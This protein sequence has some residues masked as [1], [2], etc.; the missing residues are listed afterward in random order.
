MRRLLIISALTILLAGLTACP[1]EPV[2]RF[3]A[4][5]VG[6]DVIVPEA[7]ALDN[8]GQIAG[9]LYDSKDVL[10]P[11]L[12]NN[13]FTLLATDSN[14]HDTATAISPQGV[15]AGVSEPLAGSPGPALNALVFWIYTVRSA[16]NPS[17]E[18]LAIYS[19]NNQLQAAGTKSTEEDGEH[20][21]LWT[22]T[23]TFDLPTQGNLGG[24]ALDINSR[25]QVVGYSRLSPDNDSTTAA[26]W[27]VSGLQQLGGLG[28]AHSSAN[29]ISE[30]GIVV[31]HS[32]LATTEDVFHAWYY[33]GQM[34]I[35]LGTL[36]GGNSL[37]RDI[38]TFRQIVGWSQD[39]SGAQRAVLWELNED[40]Q[41]EIHNLRDELAGNAAGLNVVD[42]IDINDLG[43]ILAV[44][45]EGA[46]QRYVLL[47]PFVSQ[48]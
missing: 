4:Q 35:D 8:A 34:P 31:G 33:E 48:D 16:R 2:R 1:P 20:P 13:G 3:S 6:L 36:G 30:T 24:A 26:L 11:V 7:S 42:A 14:R 25:G 27:T 22:L 5:D 40:G 28:G 39:A 45:Q 15:V 41:Y 46:N 18:T 38:N 44:V 17:A 32:T 47:N 10:Q 23:G 21:A 43:Q 19:L 9:G 12:W 37:A 29:A